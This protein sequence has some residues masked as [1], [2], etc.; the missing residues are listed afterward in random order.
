MRLDLFDK[1]AGGPLPAAQVASDSG[2]PE[3]RARHLFSAAAA[4]DLLEFRDPDSVGLGKLGATMVANESLRAL[5]EHHSLVYADLADPVGLFSD[6]G[7]DTRM[8]ALWPYARSEQP[9][10]LAAEDVASYTALMAASQSMVAE[11]VIDAFAFRRRS[12]LLDIGGGAGV[13]AMAVARR[14]RHLQVTVADLP[15]VAD[16]ARNAVQ[17]AGLADRISVVGAD[18]TVD[19]LPTGFD[20]VSLVRILHDHDDERATEILT[21]AHAALAADGTLLIAEPVAG[22]DRAGALIDAYFNVYLLAMGSGRPRSLS[23]LS[24]LLGEAGFGPPVRHRTTVPLVTSVLS[25]K[26]RDNL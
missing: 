10:A 3:S 9:D 2:L 5:V 24:A 23:E 8:S 18:V 7:I 22:P 21:A 15:A 17:D 19:A 12:S 13:F 26:R 20:V 14:W 6:D 4:I 1:L 11:Q 25:A 16:L